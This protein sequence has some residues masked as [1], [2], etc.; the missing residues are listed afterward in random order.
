VTTMFR[1]RPC[2]R[3]HDDVDV[4]LDPQSTRTRSHIDTEW[5]NRIDDVNGTVGRIITGGQRL[6]S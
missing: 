4:Q 6:P 5:A 3:Y 1:D 2:S